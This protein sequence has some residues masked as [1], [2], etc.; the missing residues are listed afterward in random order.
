MCTSAKIKAVSSIAIA[1]VAM[2]IVGCGSD[3]EPLSWS[4]R[5]ADRP[6]PDLQTLRERSAPDAT[7]E[8]AQEAFLDILKLR[9]VPDE[10]AVPVLD[11]IISDNVHTGR[12][13]KYAAAQA[14]FC[15]DTV[16]AHNV[17]AKC[18][19]NGHY[20]ARS[21]INYSFHWDMDESKRDAFIEQYHLVSISKDLD[22]RLDAQTRR[23]EG[24]L[25]IDFTATLRNTSDTLLELKD[26]KSCPNIL[27]C[28]KDENGKFIRVNNALR[29]LCQPPPVSWV[30]L[31]P[32]KTYQYNI[33]AR[34]KRAD[35]MQRRY[36]RLPRKS[37]L[38]LCIDH[39]FCAIG[40]GTRFSV[41]AMIEESHLPE[42][43]IE[44][45]KL[46]NPW[47]G[48]VVSAPVAIDIS[49]PAR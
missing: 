24:I 30:K 3:E 21:G 41:Y 15:I 49:E 31:A 47:T 6:V 12:I 35:K 42:A 23:V 39:Q 44:H 40:K 27:L 2:L 14:L 13:H 43:Q 38:V 16:E 37:D 26:R 34:V 32:G 9:E 18:T 36:L 1:I 22:V 4:Q 29:G 33:A 7:T 20:S 17:L 11:Q 5:V 46:K 28:C 48:R 8:I 45:C 25:H 19:Q 10:R